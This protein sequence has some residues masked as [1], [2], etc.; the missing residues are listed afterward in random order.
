MSASVI[1]AVETETVRFSFGSKKYS[2]PSEWILPS[3]MAPIT[4]PLAL[5]KGEPEL[6]PMMSLSEETLNTV[7]SSTLPLASTQRGASW[8]GGRPALL[9]YPHTQLSHHPTTLP[10]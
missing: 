8:N 2:P 3:K 1:A 6:P 7:L 5:I 9:S 4:S 10:P